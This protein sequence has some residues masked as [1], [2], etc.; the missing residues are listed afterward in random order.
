MGAD[1]QTKI[2]GISCWW[3]YCIYSDVR[4]Q[5]Y[6]VWENS[7]VTPQLLFGSDQPR[8]VPSSS[9]KIYLPH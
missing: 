6:S 7:K 8:R 5:C 4:P 2:G 3:N 1:A 9:F